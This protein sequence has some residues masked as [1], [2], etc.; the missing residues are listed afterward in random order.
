MVTGVVSTLA[1]SHSAVS[2]HMDGLGT[3]AV[4]YGP[5]GVCVSS[6]GDVFVA[7]YM[8]NNIRKISSLGQ[9]SHSTFH[10]QLDIFAH[11]L[12]CLFI[13][14]SGVDN[15]RWRVAHHWIVCGW[16]GHFGSTQFSVWH[17]RQQCWHSVRCGR[18]QQQYSKDD[19]IR[20][21]VGCVKQ[22]KPFSLVNATQEWCRLLLAA[23]QEMEDMLM[24]LRR[25]SIT[26]EDWH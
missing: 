10:N 1:G 22:D 16:I 20:L 23:R 6:G 15:G 9:S 21:I 11:P 17:R 7:E 18:T 26:R 24:E 19:L 25:C 8:T 5:S 4:F 12:L 3:L 2:G 14:R 13:C